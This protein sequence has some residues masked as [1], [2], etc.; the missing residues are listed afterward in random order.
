MLH[1]YGNLRDSLKILHKINKGNNANKLEK[2][3][4]Y[5]AKNQAIETLA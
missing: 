1:N 2:V 5:E 4:I 3:N